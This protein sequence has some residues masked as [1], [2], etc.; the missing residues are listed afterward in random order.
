MFIEN[1]VLARF[2]MGLLHRWAGVLRDRFAAV[3]T[4]LLVLLNGGLVGCS[5]TGLQRKIGTFVWHPQ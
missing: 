2:L 5:C 3:L 4:P 1:L